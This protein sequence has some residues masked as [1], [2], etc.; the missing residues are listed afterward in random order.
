MT[1]AEQGLRIQPGWLYLAPP[2]HH[3]TIVP[4]G[5]LLL[6]MTPTEHHMRPA[7]DPLF[8][9]AAQVYGRR[10][11][12]VVL[13]G[14]GADGTSGLKAIGAA[15]GLRVV[16]DI[17][18]A[19]DPSMPRSASSDGCLEFQAKVKDI[20]PLLQRLLERPAAAVIQ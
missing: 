13:T 14:G 8:R 18:E 12:G 10:V 20:G 15:G 2:D 11:I 16:Q 1:Y 4:P 9:L 17:L 6:T 19:Q 7:A 3:L 5:R